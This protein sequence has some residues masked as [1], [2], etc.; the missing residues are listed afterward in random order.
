MIDGV[1]VGVVALLVLCAIWTLLVLAR[2][3]VR[4]R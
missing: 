4:G 2:K 1:T 3:L